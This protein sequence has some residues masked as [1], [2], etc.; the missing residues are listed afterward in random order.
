MVAALGHEGRA[1]PLRGHL[2]A[3]AIDVE[4]L[5]AREIERLEVDVAD[6]RVGVERVLAAS[7]RGRFLEQ[8]V[9]I[10]GGRA[11]AHAAVLE[12]ALARAIAIEL[13]A[14]AVRIAQIQRL[15]H[16]MVGRAGQA[17]IGRRQ[18][19]ELPGER[20][21]RRHPKREVEQVGGLRIARRRRGAPRARADAV[22]RRRASP[23]RPGARAAPGRAAADSSRLSVRDRSRRG[24]SPRTAGHR[25]SAPSS[26]PPAGQ[27]H[28]AQPKVMTMG[29]ADKAHRDAAF[30]SSLSRRGQGAASPNEPWAS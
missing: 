10:Q 4:R 8:S 28:L 5:G 25:A 6:H 15:A 14:M 13:D 22:R 23:L 30:P 7:A 9:E 18:A 17:R 11:H 16:V 29:G 19:G 1:R 21:P 20:R 26:D 24:L 3:E 12:P 2:E 27:T